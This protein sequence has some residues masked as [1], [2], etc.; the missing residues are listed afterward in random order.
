[1]KQWIVVCR[2]GREYTPAHAEAQRRQFLRHAG[3][4][5]ERGWRFVC[6]TD[7]PSEDWHIP[8]ESGNRGW[9]SLMEMFR[10]NGPNILTGLDTIL[11]G[12]IDP[13]TRLAEDC[14]RDILFGIRDFYRPQKWASGVTLW[15]G[16]WR[17]L[18]ELCGPEEMRRFRGD[19]DFIEDAI[20]SG[21]V[22]GRLG[23]LQ[24]HP[25]GRGIRSFKAHVL[26]NGLDSEANVVCFHGIP[27]PWDVTSDHQWIRDALGEHHGDHHSLTV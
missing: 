13:L 25:A 12:D 21:L 23:F 5:I 16:D 10:F 4:A 14:P 15:N 11:V 22:P 3:P 24:D 26:R 20:L 9:W 27:R 6:L 1:M 2:S 8:L 17:A 19:Q 7:Q 18:Y